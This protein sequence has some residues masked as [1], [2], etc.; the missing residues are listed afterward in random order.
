MVKYTDQLPEPKID[1]ANTGV[2]SYNSVEDEPARLE[3]INMDRENSYLFSRPEL[4]NTE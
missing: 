1:V 4:E 2:C 3:Q